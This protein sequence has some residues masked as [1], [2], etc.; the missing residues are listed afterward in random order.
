MTCEGIQGFRMQQQGVGMQQQEQQINM[1]LRA[2]S[3]RSA[4]FCISQKCFVLL[5]MLFKNMLYF[6][7]KPLKTWFCMIPI[8]FCLLSLW[9]KVKKTWNYVSKH[10]HKSF[11]RE[12][13]LGCRG[14]VS[15]ESILIAEIHINN[16]MVYYIP[17]I[18][19]HRLEAR[20]IV[21]HL[22]LPCKNTLFFF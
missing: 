19:R 8:S 16:L 21:L 7:L 1:P 2:L 22:W 18:C 13:Y 6:V 9:L 5:M 4:P 10:K 15:S 11:W 12:T 14:A 17:L 3:A 20:V